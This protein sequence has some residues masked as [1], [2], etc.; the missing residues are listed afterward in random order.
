MRQLGGRVGVHN[1]CVA[2]ANKMAR[3]ARALLRAGEYGRTPEKLQGPV[4]SCRC[5]T[6]G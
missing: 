1:A 3:M 6:R 4:A 5:N 2:V